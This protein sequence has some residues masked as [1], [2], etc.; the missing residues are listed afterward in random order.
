MVP[1]VKKKICII[2]IRA[3]NMNKCFKPMPVPIMNDRETEIKAI[4]RKIRLNNI[5]LDN[6]IKRKV[7]RCP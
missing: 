1:A 7:C 5:T 2:N 4:I 6:Q 3:R